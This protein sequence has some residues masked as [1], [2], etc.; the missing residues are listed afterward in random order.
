MNLVSVGIMDHLANKGPLVTNGLDVND[1]RAIITPGRKPYH[2][3]HILPQSPSL[4]NSFSSS[5]LSFDT[6][7]NFLF[8]SSLTFNI[9]LSDMYWPCN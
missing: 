7:S 2:E 3:W 9:A 1:L 8:A 6:D 4:Y 5:K